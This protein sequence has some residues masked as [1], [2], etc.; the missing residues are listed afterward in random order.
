MFGSIP[1]ITNYGKVTSFTPASLS[2]L[3]LWLDGNDP[4]ATGTGPANNTPISTW[5]DKSINGY[6]YTQGTGANQP[7]FKTAV[8]GSNGSVLFDGTNDYLERAYTA[9]IDTAACTLFISV[10]NTANLGTFQSPFTQRS[11]TGN[12]RGYTIYKEATTNLYNTLMGTGGATWNSF[13]GPL[14][15]NNISQILTQSL[16]NGSAATRVNG[17]NYFGSSLVYQRE[18]GGTTSPSRVGAGATEGAANF[19]WTGYV[20][21]VVMYGRALSALEIATVENYLAN[22][23]SATLFNPSQVSGLSLWVD[24]NNP[25]G[26][27][28]QPAAASARATWADISGLGNNASQGVGANQPTYQV[29]IQSQKAGIL[30]DGSNDNLSGTIAGLAA[31]PA[32]SIFYV[33][34]LSRTTSTNV[35][36]G[37]G[38][39]NGTGLSSGTGQ[40]GSGPFFNVF[41]WGGEAAYYTINNTSPH[42]VTATRNSSTNSHAFYVDGN[43]LSGTSGSPAALTLANNF[44]LGSHTNP[45]FPFY[46]Q[47]YIME[48]LYYNNEVS[49]ADRISI[50]NYL[51]TKWSL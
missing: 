44:N 49:S 30:F 22:K 50:Q 11:A 5:Y 40:N 31:N 18:S 28:V 12:L 13:S 29:N 33:W 16:V 17:V 26:T 51:K 4:L 47:G 6:N 24:A 45:S 19:F 3:S 8:I 9:G 25:A 14:L 7:L 32:Y 37:L 41:D 38:N 2:S 39:A 1:I 23:W 10:R 20:N 15:T 48:L 36:F 43:A 34:K 21:E 27:G 42:Y 35:A 46:M